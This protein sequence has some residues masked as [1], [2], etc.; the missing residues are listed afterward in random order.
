MGS[1]TDITNDDDF[2]YSS[3]MDYNVKQWNVTLGVHTG[4]FV[5]HSGFVNSA[6]IN[7]GIIFSGSADELIKA[8]DVESTEN[9]YSFIR[10]IYSQHLIFSF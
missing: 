4:E 8:W 7:E 1:V 6:M 2:L 9:I 5:G 10:K 3:S